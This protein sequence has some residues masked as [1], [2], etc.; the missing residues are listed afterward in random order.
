M[1]PFLLRSDNAARLGEQYP[2]ASKRF[3]NSPCSS[4]LGSCN[5]YLRPQIHY[6]VEPSHL[7]VFR[8]S[9]TKWSPS[10]LTSPISSFLEA[11]WPYS[12]VGNVFAWHEQAVGLNPRTNKWAGN[13]CLPYSHII[14]GRHK[15]EDQKFRTVS[16]RS[17]SAA[18]Q[19]GG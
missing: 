8:D 6:I 4:C 11:S 17:P 18:Q 3:S 13:I 5:T 7:P 15:K 16:S 9:N 2:Q 10:F 14:P 19:V 12:S 1:H